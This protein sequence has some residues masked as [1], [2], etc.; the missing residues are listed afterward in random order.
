MGGGGERCIHGYLFNVFHSYSN[1][2][3]VLISREA[4]GGGEVSREQGK[5]VRIERR[6][7]RE[8]EGATM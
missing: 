1:I 2:R 6:E 5:Q 8:R 7:P 3:K 4:A